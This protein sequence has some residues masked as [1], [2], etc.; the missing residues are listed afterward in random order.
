MS[1]Y[2]IG[3]AVA[4]LVGALVVVTAMALTD[5]PEDMWNKWD[6]VES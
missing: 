3:G 2:I 5:W 1:R 4:G 6:Y